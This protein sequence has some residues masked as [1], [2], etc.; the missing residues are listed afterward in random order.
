MFQCGEAL[1][2]KSFYCW[3]NLHFPF[4]TRIIKAHFGGEK[5]PA[6]GTS[7]F[8]QLQKQATQNRNSTCASLT[9]T[10]A[11]RLFAA[12]LS[13]YVTEWRE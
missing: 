12:S 11:L 10:K 3:A 2:T 9:R 5:M 8:V 6:S 13:L 7:S 4:G 1:P